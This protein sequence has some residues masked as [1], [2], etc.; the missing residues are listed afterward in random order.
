MRFS[1]AD[2]GRSAGARSAPT[3]NVDKPAGYRGR[4]RHRR[5]DQMGAALI[6]LTPL[7]VAVRSRSAALAGPE[8]V[9]IHREAHRAAGL[10]PVEAGF[11][12]DLVEPLGLGLLL[13]EA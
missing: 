11:H 5:R 6:A 3:P 2:A 10:A 9:G 12:E 7:K 4:R 1:L 13:H 8:L